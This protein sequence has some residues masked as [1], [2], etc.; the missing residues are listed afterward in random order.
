MKIILGL[1]A[2]LLIMT[3][4]AFYFQ[5][6]GN[7]FPQLSEKT[8]TA[9]IN[10]H[11][12]NLFIAKTNKEKEVGLSEKNSIDNDQGM[13]FVFDKPD[14][15]SFW[16]RNMKFS[17]DIIF[18]NKNRI[19]TISPDANP[20]TDPSKTENLTIYKPE[21]PADTIIEIKGGLSSSYGFKKGQEVKIEGL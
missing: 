20:S 6:N 8:A 1:F 9:T 19:V 13:I 14:F 2:L 10:N 3:G 12:F 7:R 11:R 15:Y 5:K 16:M 18:V 4:A 17:I 21:D